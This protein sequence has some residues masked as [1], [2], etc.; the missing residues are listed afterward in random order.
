MQQFNQNQHVTLLFMKVRFFVT[1]LFLLIPFL[2]TAQNRE[3]PEFGL[4]LHGGLFPEFT[5]DGNEFA[6]S[7]IFDLRA[8]LY[9]QKH[10]RLEYT[11][12]YTRGYHPSVSYSYGL[13]VGYR[14][15]LGDSGVLKTSLGIENYKLRDRECRSTVRTILNAI[16]DV[17][18]SCSDDVHAS[19]NPAAALEVNIAGSVWFVAEAT[20]RLMLSSTAYE[21]ERILE[22]T[23]D[24]TDRMVTE[25]G[26]DHALYG[27]G[28]GLGTGIRINF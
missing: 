22:T 26:I 14:L 24:G 18:D 12:N 21:K 23:P 4:S 25:R 7:P 15:R 9:D 27:A 11:L 19:F 16:F 28:F 17:D 20:Y 8:H 10:T 13:S 2:L 3:E 6:E 1:V 5:L